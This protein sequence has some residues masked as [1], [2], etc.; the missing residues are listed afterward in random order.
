MF[1]NR[2]KQKCTAHY[3][4]TGQWNEIAKSYTIRAIVAVV[5]IVMIATFLEGVT[6][7]NKQT[8]QLKI[9]RSFEVPANVCT[10]VC[11]PENTW[12]Y[13]GSDIW[14][15]TLIS[16]FCLGHNTH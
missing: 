9:S 16:S 14:M 1:K 8:L 3:E 15:I 4:L 12:V 13:A 5:L 6:C 7:K 10:Q 2:K 11:V